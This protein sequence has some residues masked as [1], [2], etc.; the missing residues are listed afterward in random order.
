MQLEGMVAIV[1]GAGSGI[2]RASAVRFAAEGAAVVVNDIHGERATETVEMITGNGGRAVP[3]E[4]NVSV[5]E[6]VE[7]MVECAV[8]SF[9]RL[10]VLFNNAAKAVPGSAVD[11]SVEDWD[12]VWRTTV[13]S[14][15]LGAKYAVPRMSPGASIISTASISGLFGDVGYMAYNAAKAGVVSLTRA[16]AIDLAPLGIRVNCV[17]PGIIRTPPTSPLLADDR[18]ASMVRA[19]VP[20]RRIGEPDDVANMVVFLSTPAAA[21]VTGQAIVVDGGMTS[22]HAMATLL[23]LRAQ[24]EH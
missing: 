13:S 24:L 16:L 15:F 4:G 7:R 20:A 23:Q 22:Q 5:P 3:F 14:V 17:C 1:T 2:G 10:D 19:V 6:H 11:L 18:L 9:N 21:Y 12:L 8:E